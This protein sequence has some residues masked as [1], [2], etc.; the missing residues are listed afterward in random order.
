LRPRHRPED[1][2][3]EVC[4]PDDCFFCGED[5]P[6]SFR[7]TLI[8]P[9]WMQRFADR[10]MKFREYIDRLARQEAP[11]HIHL[12]I[13]W[14]SNEHLRRFELRWRRWLEAIANPDTEKSIL[15]GR[16]AALLGV[17][18]Q[19]RSVYYEGFLHDCDDS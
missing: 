16:L 13:C 14:V 6:Y 8:F 15:I 17:L 9:Y 7:A 1:A 3:F 4:L 18:G 10:E 2:F 5:D 11:A 19:L 12:K